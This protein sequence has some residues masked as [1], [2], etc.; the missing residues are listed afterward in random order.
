MY[1]NMNISVDGNACST[2][3]GN[4]NSADYFANEQEADRSCGFTIR[5]MAE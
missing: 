5:P 3:F 1:P 2:T 4:K